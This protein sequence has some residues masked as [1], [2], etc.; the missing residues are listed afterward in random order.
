MSMSGARTGMVKTIT[1]RVPETTLKARVADPPV[2]CGAAPGS[3]IQ[4]TFGLRS[5]SGTIRTT[6]TTSS[7]FVVRGLNKENYKL[8]IMN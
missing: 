6:G 4:G 1:A 7:V 8:G 2:C 5:A 3:I